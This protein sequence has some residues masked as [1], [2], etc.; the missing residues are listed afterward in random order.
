[1]F[2]KPPEAPLAKDNTIQALPPSDDTTFSM[3]VLIAT[4]R[5][6]FEA[7]ISSMDLFYD[8][9]DMAFQTKFPILEPLRA[10]L[11]ADSREA[12]EL[13]STITIHGDVQLDAARQI[14]SFTAFHA[15]TA[16]NV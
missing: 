3:P 8:M 1:M 4:N 5:G 12:M 11:H 16:A 6:M 13:L 10:V 14:T 2:S 15:T 7:Y 9:F